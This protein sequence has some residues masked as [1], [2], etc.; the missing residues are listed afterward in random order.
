MF[1]FIKQTAMSIETSYETHRQDHDLTYRYQSLLF[2]Y[3]KQSKFVVYYLAK[4]YLFPL[5]VVHFVFKD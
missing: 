1:T 4:T 3:F 5:K 2:L